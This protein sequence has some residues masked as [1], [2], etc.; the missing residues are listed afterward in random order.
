MAIPLSLI[1]EF[2]VFR[3]VG[4]ASLSRLSASAQLINIPAGSV[5]FEPMATPTFLIAVVEGAL[6]ATL[7]ADGSLVQKIGAF[8]RGDIIGWL[9]VIDNKPSPVRILSAKPSS[10]I[11]IPLPVAREI[12]LHEP[13]VNL[14]VLEQL[15]AGM[16]QH[17]NERR[18]LSLAN[19][20]QRV[21]MLL[22]QL[23]ENGE[24][25]SGWP[26]QQELATRANTSR[27]TVSRAIQLLVQ[28]GIIRKEGHQLV[29]QDPGQLRFLAAHGPKVS[30]SK[31]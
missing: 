18:V 14:Q 17:L 5:V 3:S 31:A 27:E 6:E 10:L 24:P 30:V 4:A 20:F 13:L 9:S 2:S 29:V 16:R 23:F 1:Q 25:S 7:P 21:F 19:A 28:S 15:A 22:S 26:R 11:L 8:G 12:L